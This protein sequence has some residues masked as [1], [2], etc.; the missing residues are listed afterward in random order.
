MIAHTMRPGE[1]L[2]I[3]GDSV[4]C[5]PMILFYFCS[6]FYHAL[7][8][9][10]VKRVFRGAEHSAIYHGSIERDLWLVTFGIFWV[11][12]VVGVVFFV[13]GSRLQYGP[14]I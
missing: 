8:P 1:A 14:F 3:V 11:E 12:A 13:T 4:F 5:A 9:G 7:S 6:M 2:L 10:K